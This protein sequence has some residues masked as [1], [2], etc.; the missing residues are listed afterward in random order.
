LLYGLAAIL[1]FHSAAFSQNVLTC[2]SNNGKR[3][4]CRVDT[5]RGVRMTRQV[6]G[7]PCNLGSTWGFDQDGIW[8]DRGCRA[9]FQVGGYARGGYPG[10]SVG[11]VIT[12]SSNDGRRKYCNADT[13]AG[14]RMTRQLSKPP[15]DQNRT[16]GYDRSG[17][18][19]DRGCRAEFMV[20]NF[21]GGGRGPGTP[22]KTI[23]NCS[24]NDGRR[25]W[26]S[27]DTEHYGARLVRQISGSPCRQGETWG[28]QPGSVWVDRGCRADFEVVVP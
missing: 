22:P 6:S 20:G 19:V 11:N 10:G 4:Y 27:A 2:S 8:V 13:R 25:H 23:I 5:S 12:C 7:S 18:W 14:V 21:N 26:C 1:F 16:W 28:M 24:S 9:E 17:I 15:C 3:N